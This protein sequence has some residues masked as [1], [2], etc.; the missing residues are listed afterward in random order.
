M[1]KVNWKHPKQKELWASRYD[2]TKKGK[3]R[4]FQL[5]NGRKTKSFE[6][7]QAAKKEGWIRVGKAKS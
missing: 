7:W 4:V 2:N 3:D 6:S 5:Y 1:A